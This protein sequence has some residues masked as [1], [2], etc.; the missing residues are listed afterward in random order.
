MV[1]VVSDLQ[2]EFVEK[3]LLTYAELQEEIVENYLIIYTDIQEEVV[4]NYLLIY[5]DLQEEVIQNYLLTYTDLQEE[6]EFLEEVTY[7]KLLELC[8]GHRLGCHVTD[9]RSGSGILTND[10]ETFHLI[11]K[12]L[13]RCRKESIGPYF[14]VSRLTRHLISHVI[15]MASISVAY[16]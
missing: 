1:F 9:L 14:I 12:E 15:S 6:R 4:Q 11:E 16:H 13:Q 7:P 8:E 10:L 3:Y 2:E 5:T